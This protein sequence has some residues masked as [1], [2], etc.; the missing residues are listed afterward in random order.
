MIADSYIEGAKIYEQKIRTMSDKQSEA[1]EK[2][3]KTEDRDA[4]KKR[5]PAGRGSKPQDNKKAEM[6]SVVKA[7]KARKLVAAGTADEV[8]IQAELENSETAVET[9]DEASE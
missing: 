4:S 1:T 2:V 3:A 5:A 9:T 6:P 8:E 7:T